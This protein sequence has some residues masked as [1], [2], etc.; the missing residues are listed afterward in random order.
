MQKIKNFYLRFKIEFKNHIQSN[1]EKLIQSIEVKK[2][3]VKFQIYLKFSL[4]NAF[5][6]IYI[7]ISYISHKKQIK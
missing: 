5:L 2:I 3:F 4:I 1:Q 7:Y 6:Y